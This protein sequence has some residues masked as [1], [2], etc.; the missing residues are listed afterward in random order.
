MLDPLPGRESHLIV[1]AAAADALVLVPMGE[2]ALS[3]GDSV[4][5]LRSLGPDGAFALFRGRAPAPAVEDGPPD[6]PPSRPE[7]RPLGRARIRRVAARDDRRQLR[8]DREPGADHEQRGKGD[9]A[10]RGE[11]GEVPRRV[12]AEVEP[13]RRTSRA[14]AAGLRTLPRA[15]AAWSATDRRRSCGS[16]IQAWSEGSTNRTEYGFIATSRSEVTASASRAPIWPASSSSSPTGRRGSR[17]SRAK[18]QATASTHENRAR[19]TTGQSVPG[20]S[21]GASGLAAPVSQIP[22]IENSSK[23][24][25]AKIQKASRLR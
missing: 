6:E 16:Q 17:R 22:R 1:R 18:S 20:E 12:E 4:E 21:S 7:A 25:A 14:A 13:E 15:R 5:F 8:G 24:R 19:P 23:S 9:V 10:D 11:L 3:A 2:S